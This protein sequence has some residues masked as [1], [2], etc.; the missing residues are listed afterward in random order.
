MSETPPAFPALPGQGWSVHK[1]PTFA[2]RLAPHVSGREVRASL[3]AAPLWE[4]EVTFDGPTVKMPVVRD[5]DEGKAEGKD[6]DEPQGEGEKPA[7]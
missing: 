3:Y 5:E 2:T 7:E 4:F 1:R 6:D